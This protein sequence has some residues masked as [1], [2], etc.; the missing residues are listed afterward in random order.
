MR[1]VE[2]PCMHVCQIV[3]VRSSGP[4]KPWNVPPRL[5]SGPARIDVH[6]FLAE[7]PPSSGPTLGEE[8]PQPNYTAC[9]C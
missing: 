4:E 7:A 6:V 5:E 1:K 2:C 9:K 8:E 3:T